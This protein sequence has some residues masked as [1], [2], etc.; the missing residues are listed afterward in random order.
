MLDRIDSQN[1][2][3]MRF[4]QELE[5]KIS[6]R[7]KELAGS[8]LELQ[9]QNELV[10]TILDSSVDLIAVVDSDLKYV[11]INKAAIK[12]Y[13]KTSEELIGHP[14]TEV[15]PNLR[16]SEMVENLQTVLQGRMVHVEKYYSPILNGYLDSFY[17]PI[18]R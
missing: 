18:I 16:S 13:G 2:D 14:M 11:I 3:I 7:T 6:E 1:Q 5:I 12:A 15:F 17:I 10:G 8:N 4:N 9:Q